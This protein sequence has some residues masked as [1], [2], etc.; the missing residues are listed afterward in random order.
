MRSF[1][2]AV[3]ALVLALAVRAAPAPLPKPDPVKDDLKKI[4]GTWDYT[5]CRMA[6]RDVAVTPGEL[7]MVIAGNRI[8]IRNRSGIVTSDWTFTLDARKKPKTMDM[9]AVSRDFWVAGLLSIYL[10]EGDRFKCCHNSGS[11]GRPADFSAAGA[12][13]RLDVWKRRK[14]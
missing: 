6:G 4:Q 10:V 3:A 8:T 11:G 13:Q 14:R 7:V 9:K 5:G 2:T 12:S 1:A